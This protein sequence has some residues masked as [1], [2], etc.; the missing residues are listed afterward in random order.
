MVYLV[1]GRQN[2]VQAA[3][4][5]SLVSRRVKQAD[6]VD[7]IDKLQGFRSLIYSNGTVNGTVVK[8]DP[9]GEARAWMGNITGFIDTLHHIQDDLGAEI[10]SDTLYSSSAQRKSTTFSS[11]LLVVEFFVYPVFIFLTLRLTNRVKDY[12]KKLAER[13][14]ILA[15]E[16]RRNATLVKEMY[17][18]SVAARLLKGNSV[19]P[20][21]FESATVCFSGL[22]DFQELSRIS[23]G[24]DIIF[25]INRLFDLMDDE[26]SKY[27]VFKVETVG[28]QYLVV[29][30]VPLRNGDSHVKEIANM[31]LGLLEQTKNLTVDHLPTYPIQ[32][33]FGV[34][35]GSVVAGIV[36]LKMPRYCLFDKSFNILLNF[37]R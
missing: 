22:S 30:G 20:E 11:C 27:D 12:S 15:R 25:F 8:W 14:K 24:V 4:F 31:A 37:F 5:S 1:R 7:M 33:K 23:H 3:E 16:Q 35:T 6:F 19:E 28:D 10:L 34:C 36:G 2:L 29:S 13:L 26:I 21:I 17:P 32:L 18:A 9:V